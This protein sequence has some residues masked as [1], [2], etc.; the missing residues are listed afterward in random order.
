MKNYIKYVIALSMILCQL[1]DVYTQIGFHNLLAL[2][3][4][5]PNNPTAIAETE[6]EYLV[7]GQYFDQ[8]I[9]R[10][11]S[12]FTRYTKQGEFIEVLTL[13]NDTTNF[14][15]ETPVIL[16]NDYDY[17]AVANGPL[18]SMK[19]IEYQEDNPSINTYLSF[20]KK[21]DDFAPTSF[22]FDEQKENFF[23]SGR[24]LD[25]GPNNDQDIKL[26][27]IGQLETK[28]FT[29]R[30]DDFIDRAMTI[31]QD[32]DGNYITACT[33]KDKVTL[34]DKD[35]ISQT[36]ISIF[37]QDLNL[38]FY[39]DIGVESIQMSL[40]Y[41]MLLDQ[42]NN[43][44]VTGYDRIFN[45]QLD[46]FVNH[47]CIAKFDSSGQPLW[48]KIMGN[49]A[50][51][52][53]GYGHWQSIIDSK[54]G[55][56][57]IVVGAQNR[58]DFEMDSAYIPTAAIAKLSYEGDSLWTRT[59]SFRDAKSSIVELFSDV[60]LSEDGHYVACGQSQDSD[61]TTAVLPWIQ[62]LIVKMDS[63]GIYDTT[64]VSTIDGMSEEENCIN[65]SSTQNQSR[66][67][68]SQCTDKEVKV[69]INSMSGQII[70]KFTLPNSNHTHILN[71]SHFP[72]GIYLATTVGIGKEIN[73][74][75]FLIH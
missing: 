37:D 51:N 39:P 5:E 7:F 15:E 19:L 65:I 44:I 4:N 23:F 9:G 53:I 40:G 12:M 46:A 49:N 32:K 11:T 36:Y 47:A 68:F 62:S 14:I 57:Y 69:V 31:L 58:L 33:R 21:K 26:L 59:Y 29:I 66:I 2:E 16:S 71:T 56:G 43:I 22:S 45:E 24:N 73:S 75:K 61:Y 25:L 27:R 3:L 72:P 52:T 20:D 35:D 74:Q 50:G 67:Y 13:T 41:G 60:I 10:W 34:S 30:N 1:H 63:N 38:V 54:E 55:D 6:N 28:T 42:Y 48:K 70:E 18:N 64:S 8:E 17:Y